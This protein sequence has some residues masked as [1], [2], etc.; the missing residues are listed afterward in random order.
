MPTANAGLR[1]VAITPAALVSVLVFGQ[2]KPSTTAMPNTAELPDH[3]ESAQQHEGTPPELELPPLPEGMTADEVFDYA[4]TDPPA[5]FP[6][7]VHDDQLFGFLLFD[8]FEYRVSDNDA[9]D[10]LAWEADG[11]FGGDINK[12]WWKSEGEAIF[13]GPDQGESE[14]DFLYSRLFT[15]FWSIQTGVQ[16]ANEWNDGNEDRWS[17]VLALQGLAPYRFELDNSLYISEDGD[18]TFEFEGEYDL[19]ITQRLVLQPRAALSVAA[20]DIPERQLGSGITST[21]IDLRL[22]YEI[23][24]D[25]ASYMGI[26]YHVLVGETEDIAEAAGEETEKWLFLAGLRFAF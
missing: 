8:Q 4:E 23:R 19:R 10:R 2:S 15:P 16:Y 21:D 11:W 24:R 9:P 18:V 13:D 5:H 6:D 14:N 26:G 7:P 12:F 20:Q 3:Q 1:L 17:Y 22:R 25:F